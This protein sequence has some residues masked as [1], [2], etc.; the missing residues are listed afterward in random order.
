MIRHRAMDPEP[1]RQR[2]VKNR[3]IDSLH[4]WLKSHDSTKRK[5]DITHVLLK[6]NN[7]IKALTRE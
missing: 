6:I 3:S 1:H 2:A 7:K 5:S 4:D